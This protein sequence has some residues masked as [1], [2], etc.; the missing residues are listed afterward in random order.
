M[1]EIGSQ[2]KIQ[3]SVLDLTV[4]ERFLPGSC[5]DLKDIFD[6]AGRYNMEEVSQNP[7]LGRQFYDEVQKKLDVIRRTV[8]GEIFERYLNFSLKA[9][10]TNN[11]L[12]N[13][14]RIKMELLRALKLTHLDVRDLS[15]LDYDP[16]NFTAGEREID[17]LKLVVFRCVVTSLILKL[18]EDKRFRSALISKLG[19]FNKVVEQYMQSEDTIMANMTLSHVMHV[20]YRVIS[21]FLRFIGNFKIPDTFQM[22][23]VQLGQLR[24]VNDELFQEILKRR[25]LDLSDIYTYDRELGRPL[26]EVFVNTADTNERDMYISE[27]VLDGNNKNWESF[28]KGMMSNLSSV[29]TGQEL[30]NQIKE[31]VAR[32]SGRDIESLEST[33]DIMRQTFEDKH[34]RKVLCVHY[35]A[36]AVGIRWSDGELMIPGTGV[37]FKELMEKKY[38]AW[39]EVL[40][41]SLLSK[42]RSLLVA[43]TKDT[44]KDVMDTIRPGRR[45]QNSPVK[46]INVPEIHKKLYPI[47]R[48]PGKKNP[49]DVE[50]DLKDENDTESYYK[51]RKVTGHVRDLPDGMYAG[52]QAVQNAKNLGITLNSIVD[53]EGVLHYTQ[54]FVKTHSS[55]RAPQNPDIS[56]EGEFRN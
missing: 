54:T 3:E 27:V 10:P 42:L 24:Q 39:V 12:A 19:E 5:L 17:E 16:E 52:P 56:I 36:L 35:N 46:K 34:Q 48:T 20:D 28:L 49:E 31:Q 43:E 45:G 44:T 30:V 51:P 22:N 21:D 23:G 2:E 25:N 14:G 41:H 13:Y 55:P 1:A 15:Q 29:Y 6:L 38:Q 9:N 40:R 4:L 37:P 7:V 18:L 26:V 8:V 11:P 50:P 47:T 32:V 53:K 33:A